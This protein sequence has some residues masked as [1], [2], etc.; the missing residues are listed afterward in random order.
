MH[1]RR[2]P[3]KLHRLVSMGLML[4]A[5]LLLCWAAIAVFIASIG[6]KVPL[7]SAT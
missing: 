6:L 7:E 5:V 2:I 4:G 1:L 3:H